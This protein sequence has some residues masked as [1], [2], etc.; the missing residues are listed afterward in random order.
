M[1]GLFSPRCPLEIGIK[2]WIERRFRDLAAGIGAERVRKAKILTPGDADV[3]QIGSGSEQDLAA[4]FAQVCYLMDLSYEDFV[5]QT[6]EDANLG[7]ASG[8]YIGP[9]APEERPRIVIAQSL[10]QDPDR[11]LATSAYLVGHEVIRQKFPEIARSQD[12]SWAIDLVA[13]CYGLGVFAANSLRRGG[14]PGCGSGGCSSC[15]PDETATKGVLT[16]TNYGHV[17]ALLAWVRNE[18]SPEWAE[19]V[20]GEVGHTMKASLKYLAKSDD[21][22]FNKDDF[23]RVLENRSVNDFRAILN[24]PLKTQHFEALRELVRQSA[25]AEEL[26]TDIEPFLRHRATSVRRQA[27]AAL[28]SVPKLTSDTFLEMLRLMDD[29][30]GAVRGALTYA[31]RPGCGEE[32][33][34]LEALMKLINDPH[35]TTAGQ[36]AGALLQF[37]DL[38]SGSL[39]AGLK[40]LRRGVAKLN[41]DVVAVALDL[42]KLLT[43]DVESLVA[44]K[45]NDDDDVLHMVNGH[46]HPE[47]ESDESLSLPMAVPPS[48]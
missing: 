22:A 5:L 17:L 1:F 34:A 16:P 6:T 2:A 25:A 36:A 40:L 28:S 29:S 45:F 20:S 3:P 46:L 42:L 9:K 21:C 19:A 11:L 14:V 8:V 4:M 30:E 18:E 12:V 27:A 31:L 44:A 23:G 43:D 33:L 35:L 41:D 7:G 32:Q 47:A 37:D 39:D 48:V 38:P 26:A 13:A 15:G 10:P 24:S